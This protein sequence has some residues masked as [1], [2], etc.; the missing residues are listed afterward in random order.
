[1]EEQIALLTRLQIIE[2]NSK[3]TEQRIAEIWQEELGVDWVD[4]HDNFFDL[5]GHSLQ[6]IV[7][8]GRSWHSNLRPVGGGG[9]T[10]SR[11]MHPPGQAH[12]PRRARP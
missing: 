6:A 3:Q 5:G 1:M 7:V 12:G 8:T 2:I 10:L 11:Q 9:G 4:V